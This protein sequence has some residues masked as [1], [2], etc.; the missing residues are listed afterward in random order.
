MNKFFKGEQVRLA[1]AFF[2][3]KVGLSGTVI[4]PEGP[5]TGNVF[6]KFR[7][8]KE[9]HS[10]DGRMLWG[11][12]S[13][14][15][16][17]P[18][19][20]ERVE[21][22]IGDTVIGID[23]EL[24]Y[25][26]GRKGQVVNYSPSGTGSLGV[27]WQGYKDGH[28][29]HGYLDKDATNGWYVPPSSLGVIYRARKPRVVKPKPA[30]P[31]PVKSEPRKFNLG[32]KVTLSEVELGEEDLRGMV[33]T[34]RVLPDSV[35]TVYGVE[36]P[37]WEGGHRLNGGV[38]PGTGWWVSAFRLK[39]VEDPAPADL[40]EPEAVRIRL[41]RNA[42]DAKGVSHSTG[43]WYARKVWA[44]GEEMFIV[45]YGHGDNFV[46]DSDNVDEVIP[47]E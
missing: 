37:R 20:L 17:P 18:T 38:P 28:F 7:R 11:S 44:W 8:F 9:G 21:P 3:A 2:A 15:W 13:G 26:Y 34:I 32:D 5:E 45:S 1:K 47:Q 6:V 36:F 14:Y 46:V 27:A 25:L 30:E 31:A 12:T 33:G 24:S 35:V 40:R 10:G 39:K 16:V 23:P 4:D 22:G 29:L 43:P 19:H 41:K 42:F